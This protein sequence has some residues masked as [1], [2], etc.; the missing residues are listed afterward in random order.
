MGS[1]TACAWRPPA[2]KKKDE[3]ALNKMPLHPFL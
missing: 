2:E 3:A 1:A